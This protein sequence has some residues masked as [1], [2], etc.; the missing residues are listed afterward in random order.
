MCV[1]CNLNEVNCVREERKCGIVQHVG[2][3]KN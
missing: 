2:E 1:L 3:I